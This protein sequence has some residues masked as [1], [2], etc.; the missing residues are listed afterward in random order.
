MHL[1]MKYF[2]KLSLTQMV[3]AVYGQFFCKFIVVIVL[4]LIIFFV[5]SSII[6]VLLLFFS[7]S[8]AP[9]N[10][11]V[12]SFRAICKQFFSEHPGDIIGMINK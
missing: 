3:H 10:E 2:R 12:R 6:I 5:G 11:Q 4:S 9:T 7:Y 8:A 1:V